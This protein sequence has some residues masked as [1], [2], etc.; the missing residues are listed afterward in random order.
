[1]PNANNDSASLR[2]CYCDSSN[3]SKATVRGSRDYGGFIIKLGE[4]DDDGMFSLP[5]P[6]RNDFMRA[7][8]VE[9]IGLPVLP[10]CCAF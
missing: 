6:H 9:A 10:I 3:V 8:L 4:S 1:V 7:P 5:Q 2:D